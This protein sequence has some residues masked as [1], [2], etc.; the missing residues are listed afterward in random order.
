MNKS[1]RCLIDAFSIEKSQQIDNPTWRFSFRLPD[2][3]SVKA[4]HVLRPEKSIICLSTQIGCLGK[5]DFCSAAHLDWKR[6]LSGDELCAMIDIMVQERLF[7]HNYLDKPL[8]VSFM[9]TGEPLANIVAVNDVIDRWD[10]FEVRFA[11][12]TSGYVLGNLNLLQYWCKVQFTLVTTNEDLRLNLQP[13]V[14]PLYALALAIHDYQGKKEINV[15]LISGINDDTGTI[16]DI[17]AFAKTVQV[18]VKLNRLNELCGSP[19]RA[20]PTEKALDLAA[21]H[22]SFE[23]YET[24]GQDVK[25]ACGQFEMSV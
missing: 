13:H 6:N 21:R 24:D 25:A 8:L 22:S 3:Y 4:A 7:D 10:D 11:L 20:V 15:P 2:G 12:S 9:G 19:Y 17:A 23:Y 1:Q 18:P 14:E 5:C 16:D